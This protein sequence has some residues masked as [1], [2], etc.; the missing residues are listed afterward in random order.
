MI[1][2]IQKILPFLLV[3][4][5]LIGCAPRNI[6]SSRPK[7]KI[8]GSAPCS[9]KQQKIE[10]WDGTKEYFTATYKNVVYV[11]DEPPV[12][13]VTSPSGLKVY[14]QQDFRYYE[15]DENGERVEIR[16]D[17]KKIKRPR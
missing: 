9:V 10:T 17:G 16:L 13:Y 8:S 14:F 15:L 1:K 3:G 5:L 6:V 11:Q 12:F 2:K 4:V 7:P